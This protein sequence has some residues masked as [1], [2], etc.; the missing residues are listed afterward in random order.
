M[1]GSSSANSSSRVFFHGVVLAR[2]LLCHIS[3]EVF[4]LVVRPAWKAFRDLGPAVSDL[5]PRLRHNRL[6]SLGPRAFLDV[7]V[8]F[9]VGFAKGS[10]K[11]CL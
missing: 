5:A 6:L 9:S 2:S 10:R 4:N 11:R 7:G 1:L 3:P 8:C